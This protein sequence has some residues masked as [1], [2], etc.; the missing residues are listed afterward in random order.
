MYLHPTLGTK[1]ILQLELK[2]SFLK[3]SEWLGFQGYQELHEKW[4]KE[5]TKSN[6][7]NKKN[8]QYP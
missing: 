6:L 5:K 1:Q 4:D 2:Y 7:K 3:D 8:L